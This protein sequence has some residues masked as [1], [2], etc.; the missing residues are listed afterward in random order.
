MSA[1][2]YHAPPPFASENHG[3]RM[4]FP[5]LV[6]DAKFCYLEA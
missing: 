4:A 1:V 6:D 2:S 3:R 5:Y